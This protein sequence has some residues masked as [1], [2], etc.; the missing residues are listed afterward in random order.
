MRP[1]SAP[2]TNFIVVLSG[3]NIFPLVIGLQSVCKL[4]LWDKSNAKQSVFL[5]FGC[6]RGHDRQRALGQRPGRI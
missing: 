6:S 5:R 3:E 4:K 1:S 2:G